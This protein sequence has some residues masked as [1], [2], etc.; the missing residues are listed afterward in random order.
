MIHALLFIYNTNFTLLYFT[1]QFYGGQR[2]RG[3]KMK[4][5]FIPRRKFW[6]INSSIPS[7]SPSRVMFPKDWGPDKEISLSS[8]CLVPIAGTRQPFDCVNPPHETGA[9]VCWLLSYPASIPLPLPQTHRHTNTQRPWLEVERL[10]GRRGGER[11]RVL[12]K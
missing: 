6:C 8:L 2:R 12:S 5:L 9:Y 11:I 10:R 4:S 1:W 7:N 3:R